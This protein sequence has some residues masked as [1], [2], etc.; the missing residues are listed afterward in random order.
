MGSIIPLSMKAII[1]M[2]TS[3]LFLFVT[4]RSGAQY[5][6]ASLWNVVLSLEALHTV[7]RVYK[8]LKSTN[9]SELK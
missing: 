4:T 7:E 3:P 6:K 5:C 2:T 9:L 8:V 1:G